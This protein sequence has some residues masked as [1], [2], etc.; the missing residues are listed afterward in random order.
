MIRKI[1]VAFLCLPLIG[2]A[3]SV[4]HQPIASQFN[5]WRVVGNQNLAASANPL[6]SFT[7]C[8]L[9]AG[10]YSFNA[11]SASTPIKIY[12]PG[13][14]S[15]DEVVT[16]TA[17]VVNSNG[18]TATITPSNAH[19]TPWYIGSGT[20]GLQEAINAGVLSNQLNTVILDT[21]WWQAGGTNS[22]IYAA[23]GNANAS[24]L[25]VTVSPFT[26]YGWNGT[27][28]VGSYSILG[29]ALP[30]IAAG[31][32]AGTSPT[33]TNA[34]GSL[35]TAMVANVTTGTATTT[36]TLFTETVTA[37]ALSRAVNCTLPRSI[38]ANAYTGAITFSSAAGV[39]TFSVAV[40]PAVSTAYVFE[41][42][43]N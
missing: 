37:P 9:T 41:V 40:A 14:P 7:P 4:T 12:D 36:G 1:V 17:I 30:T 13:N 31:A 21:N 23:A 11:V 3:Q 29:T 16:P 43:C 19:T 32:A 25:D 42:N 5:N 8:A 6:V 10:S 35:G 34:A 27:H 28:Y 38:G 39:A 20:F 24:V 18:C 26:A 33:V 15:A 22:I 2:S